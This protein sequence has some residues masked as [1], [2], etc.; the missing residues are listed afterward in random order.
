MHSVN[1]TFSCIRRHNFDSKL[2]QFTNQ[3]THETLKWAWIINSPLDFLPLHLTSRALPT[4]R[5]Y[6]NFSLLCFY[7]FTTWLE[8]LEKSTESIFQLTNHSSRRICTQ[9]TW[10][11]SSVYLHRS[12]ID[13][14]IKPGRET[15]LNSLTGGHSRL[16]VN[17]I[18][19]GFCQFA[20]GCYWL[21]TI[22][23]H[24]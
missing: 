19:K 2:S 9:S 15:Q 6:P 12:V 11:L 3:L 4:S 8:T 22:K 7:V 16:I 17:I 18:K 14:Y 10:T 20:V 1:L 23:F 21:R 13:I 24:V 5:D